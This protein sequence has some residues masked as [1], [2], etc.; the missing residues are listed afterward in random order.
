MSERARGFVWVTLAYVVAGVA[1]ATVV[2]AR[3]GDSGLWTAFLADVAGT[4]AIF[5]FSRVF[6]NTSFYDAYWSVAPIALAGWWAWALPGDAVRGVLVFGLVTLWGLRLTLNWATG[7]PGLHHE[8]W[9]Y[10]DFRRFGIWYWP[11]SLAGL[12]M[13]PTVQVFLGMLPVWIAARSTAPL[14]WLDG[15]AAVVTL[16]AVVIEGL[17]DLQLRA[18]VARGEGGICEEGLWR[19]SRH[20]NYFGE[21]LFWVGL[22]LFGLATEPAAWWGWTGAV[23]IIAM[24]VRVSV[25]LLDNRS[26]DRRPGYAEHMKRVSAIV[27]WFRRSA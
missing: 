22:A 6:D 23:A 26:L 1:A 5:V 4:L 21:I 10:V 14:G 19:W 27:P 17:S 16:A 13:F 12:H 11:I 24:F 3:G 18:F 9:R 15:V 20:P 2:W 8:D 25:P 7:W